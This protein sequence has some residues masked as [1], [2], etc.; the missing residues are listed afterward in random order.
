MG[1]PSR[2]YS[3]IQYESEKFKKIFTDCIYI[4]LLIIKFFR[5]IIL[6]PV[7]DLCS[8]T[9]WEQLIKITGDRSV[10]ENQNCI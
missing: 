2:F 1:L 3:D 6:I 4:C 7:R 10:Y 8:Y 5:L 9:E